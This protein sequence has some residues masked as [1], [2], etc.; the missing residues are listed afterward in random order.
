MTLAL[1]NITYG[2]NLGYTL[3]WPKT[4]YMNNRTEVL[5]AMRKAEE[6]DLTIVLPHW[7]EEYQLSHSARQEETAEWLV[8]N[9][10]HLIVGAHPHV[11]Q[12]T[13]TIKGVPVIYSLG[14]AISNMSAADTQIELM[15]TIRIVHHGN[16][17]IEMLRPELTWLWCSRPGGYSDSYTVLPVERFIGSRDMWKGGWEYDKMMATYE[18]IRKQ[19]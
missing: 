2:T 15:A 10:A 5:Q 11:V 3:H 9:G 14:N 16:G 13:A 7:G 19:H 1:V 18:R 6:A 8:E 12:D 4:N 17:D